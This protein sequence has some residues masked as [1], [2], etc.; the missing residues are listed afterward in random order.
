MLTLYHYTCPHGHAGLGDAGMLLPSARL[1]SAKG[2]TLPWWGR[3]AWLTDLEA[4]FVNALGLTRQLIPCDR[5]RYRYR[6]NAADLR[7][8]RRW[9]DVRREVREM[10]GVEALESA[11]GAMP[12][13]WFVT[14]VPVHVL[15]DEV[16]R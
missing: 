2:I 1:P 16:K 12:A 14:E 8:V 5:T 9:L 10:P 3:Y 11:P 6:L 7:L 15:L 13:H 4:P